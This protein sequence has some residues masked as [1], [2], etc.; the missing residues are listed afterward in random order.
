MSDPHS[1][2]A[3]AVSRLRHQLRKKRESLADQ[4]DFKMFVV[5]HFKRNNE[6]KKPCAVYEI[7][8]VFPVMTNNY[9]DSILKGVKEEAYTY[10][11]SLE[12]LEKDVVQFHA[13]RW[14]SMRKDV[15]GC[16]TEMDFFL[17]PRHD[18]DSIECLL[19]SRW[20]NSAD[21]PY[22]PIKAEY[23]FQC[24]DYEKQLLRLIP[25]RDKSG[26]IINNPTQSMF[27]FVDKQDVQT[28][29]KRVI[30]FKLTSACLYLPQDQLM[31]WGPG[32]VDEIMEPYLY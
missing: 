19:F 12:L 20:K 25:K 8:E 6:K 22:K 13:P 27:L 32:T 2:K 24:K 16:T 9:E 29:N 18:I 21:E 15:I 17:W 3:Q 30:M 14:Q 7:E 23:S 11:S 31:I 28:A 26:L 5:F 10:E 1:R 4:F